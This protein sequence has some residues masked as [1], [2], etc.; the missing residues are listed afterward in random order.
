MCSLSRIG[1]ACIGFHFALLEC[2][3]DSNK[4]YIA[5]PS[6][7]YWFKVAIESVSKI[8]R[9][10]IGLAEIIRHRIFGYEVDV[11]RVLERL[12]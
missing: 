10:I 12:F 2:F 5:F 4:P 1:E 11:S 8:L 9:K 3:H 7:L 6:L